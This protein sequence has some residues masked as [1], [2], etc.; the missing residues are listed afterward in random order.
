M[1]TK[2]SSLLHCPPYSLTDKNNK[3]PS[4]S[5]RRH[6]KKEHITGSSVL[7][8]RIGPPSISYKNL[9]GHHFYGLTNREDL[10]MIF[11]FYNNLQNWNQYVPLKKD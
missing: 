6:P 11:F 2:C 4:I 5:K 10:L 8:S 3:T 1:E 9:H 7:Q